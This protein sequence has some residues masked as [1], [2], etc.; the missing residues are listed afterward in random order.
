VLNPSELIAGVRLT[1]SQGRGV[2][3]VQLQPEI[4]G[5]ALV[6]LHKEDGRLKLDFSVERE[7]VR[8]ALQAETVHLREALASAGFPDASVEVHASPRHSF[9][10]DDSSSDSNSRNTPE[11]AFSS[12]AEEAPSES[13][14]DFAHPLLLGYNTFDILA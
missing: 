14:S 5:P 11:G 2:L 6:A 12:E 8:A 3:L 13:A 9:S 1:L 10:P 4:M 7:S